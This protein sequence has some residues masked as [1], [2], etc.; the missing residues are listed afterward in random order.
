MILCPP[1]IRGKEKHP[2]LGERFDGDAFS[3]EKV[4]FKTESE[5][6]KPEGDRGLGEE[7]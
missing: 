4:R 1:E 7:E 6:L 3:E 5:G 2:S